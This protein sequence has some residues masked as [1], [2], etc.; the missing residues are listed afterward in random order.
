MTVPARP[1]VRHHG[2]AHSRPDVGL[3][4]FALAVAL[5]LM[6]IAGML[7]LNAPTL[8][9]QGSP[10]ATTLWLVQS[11]GTILSFLLG[12]AAVLT[13]RGRG[14]GIAAMAIS[15]LGNSYVWLLAAATLGAPGS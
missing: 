15:V 6:L 3:T 2:P 5:V 1:T 9:G 13:G 14:W 10:S 12:V 7:L 4:A 8:S 11:S